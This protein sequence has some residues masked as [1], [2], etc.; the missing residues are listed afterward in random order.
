V[1]GMDIPNP[2]H[3][4]YV[5]TSGGG[6]TMFSS[7]VLSNS[8]FYTAAFP[9]EYGNALSGVFDMRFRNGNNARHEF[10]VQLGLQG[11]DV[12]AE[13]PFIKEKPASWLFNYRYSIWD[14]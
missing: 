5:G 14:F 11:L 1:D 4:A 8:D 10:V 12:S 9:A 13:G 7:Q 3:F 2:N 6:F